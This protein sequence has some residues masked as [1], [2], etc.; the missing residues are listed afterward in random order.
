MLANLG[1]L[2]MNH[3]SC[4]TNV[5]EFVKYLHQALPRAMQGCEQ[6]FGGVLIGKEARTVQCAS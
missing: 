2:R 6:Y 4:Y 3:P 5:G 1:R